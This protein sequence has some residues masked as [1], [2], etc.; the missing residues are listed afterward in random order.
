MTLATDNAR[1]DRGRPSPDELLEENEIEVRQRM[2][3]LANAIRTKNLEQVL[4]HYAPDVVVYD[5]LPPLDVRGIAAYRRSF[6]KWFASMAG[7]ISYDILDLRVSACDTHAMAHCLSHVTGAR[8]GGGRHDYWVRITSGWRK[9]DGQWV[10]TH[11][12]V[13]MPTMI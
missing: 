4:W 11:E 10:V 7:R 2:E 3:S 1:A 5:L 12:H 8:T 9:L 13:S 6:E